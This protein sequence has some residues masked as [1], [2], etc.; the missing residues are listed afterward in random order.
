[1]KPVDPRSVVRRSLRQPASVGSIG[2]EMNQKYSHVADEV[3]QTE[4]HHH[5][6]VQSHVSRRIRYDSMTLSRF[7]HLANPN[8][9]NGYDLLV[10]AVAA[11]M[12]PVSWLILRKL[13]EHRVVAAGQVHRRNVPGVMIAGLVLLWSIVVI[14]DLVDRYILFPC[15]AFVGAAFCACFLFDV[16]RAYAVVICG[17][18]GIGLWE[19]CCGPK[20]RSLRPRPPEQKEASPRKIGV[21]SPIRC[22]LAGARLFE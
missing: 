7:S 3:R 2:S 5:V 21:L 8:S 15:W 18:V 14:V 1:M 9:V 20:I 22:D 17:V 4:L 12:L 16:R 6:F 11:P 10:V 13:R 19:L